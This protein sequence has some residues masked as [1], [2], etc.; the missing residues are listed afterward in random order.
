MV[1][2][3][4]KRKLECE[5]KNAFKQ[6]PVVTL[7]GPRQSGK[8][9]LARNCFPKL[10]YVNLEDPEIR[11]FVSEDPRA[12]L[13]EYADGAILDE[14]QN[15]PE[16]LSFIQVL[17]DEKNKN[18][19]FV[20]T[21]S[22]QLSL[23]EAISQS[24][25]GRTA[26]LTLLPLSIAELKNNGIEFAADKHMLQGGYPRIYQQNLDPTR[27]YADYYRTY[28]QRD[29]R[30]MINIKDLNLFEKFM[31]LCAGRIGSLFEASNLANEVG[32]SSHTINNWLSILEASFIIFRLQ[33]Y[34]ENFGKR[35]IK[36]S[37]IYFT[38]V[39]LASYLLDIENITQIKRDPLRG[40]LFENMVILEL[41]KFR[42][43]Q[44]KSPNLYFYRDNH[45]N[46]VDVIFKH[47]H[48]LLPI[49]I[50]S[51]QTFNNSFLKNI[52]FYHKIAGDRAQIS[53]I[54]YA[55]EQQQKLDKTE[56]INFHDMEI[57][58]QQIA[59]DDE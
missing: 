39:G 33:P 46:E 10:P 3:M 16:L 2:N 20:L 49:E 58:W 12:F 6:Y 26:L 15:T 42:L 23:H 31:K 24:L 8:S 9:T 50:K 51:A 44:G 27:A 1:Q 36:S 47:G 13:N 55:G 45:R 21:G 32:V 37:K 7:I 28:I 40:A 34:F 54:I 48:K 4:F 41:M 11:R 17:V 56:L 53:Y 30:Q 18:S 19:L 57:I 43:N 25:A 59:A 5:L 38:D 22:H 35:V 52:K 14:I 29:V